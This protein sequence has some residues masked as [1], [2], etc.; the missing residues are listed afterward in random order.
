[1]G[2]VGLRR[3]TV[4][5]LFIENRYATR[6]YQ[7]VS[8]GLTAAGHEVHWIV[9]NPVFAPDLPNIHTLPFPTTRDLCDSGNH[10]LYARISKSDR[11]IIY[12]GR[13]NSH[14]AHY[15]KHIQRILDLVGPD[16]V[17]GEST[18]LHELLTIEE[19]RI[20]SIRY[21][22]PTSTRYPPGRL[23]FL[24]EDSMNPVGGCGET[25][26]EAEAL[27]MIQ[28][29]NQR[30]LVP[31]YMRTQ[32]RANFG[33]RRRVLADKLLIAWSWARGERYLTPSPWKKLKVDRQHAQSRVRWAGLA[34]QRYK[35]GEDKRTPYIL[36]PLQMQP[37]STIDVWGFPWNDQAEIVR[38]AGE[39]LAP[40]GIQLLV[41]PNPKP[42]YEIDERLCNVV[43]AT[44][45]VVPVPEGVPMHELFANAS[46][47]L[48]VT[49]TVL[50]ESILA[51]KKT[52]A[53]GHH[54]MSQYPS[55]SVLDK[56]QAI[57]SSFFCH[58]QSLVCDKRESGLRLIQE[59]FSSSYIAR[60]P[61]PLH[62]IKA[63]NKDAVTLL[64]LAFVDVL[65]QVTISRNRQNSSSTVD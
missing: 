63:F 28:Q 59:L 36:Y 50:I 61:D 25:M 52:F 22:F 10:P 51:G 17:F 20:R 64:E 60:V 23:C 16:V 8:P 38:Q 54:A 18:Q 13:D 2:L 49:G 53:I 41:K 12:F 21:L 30:S 43:Q 39:S 26:P 55:V 4:K 33:H 44:A 58:E 7:A 65:K 46:A 40:H 3:N 32:P 11:A 48:S 1:M 24:N 9:Q 29:I 35:Q 19:C 56:P 31:S 45:N 37:E 15:H 62:D 27:E 14:Y 34:S 42:K 5:L 6:L 57:T 47:V